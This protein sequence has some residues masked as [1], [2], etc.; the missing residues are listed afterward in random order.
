MELHNVAAATCR[1]PALGAG[2]AVRLCLPQSKQKTSV[3]PTAAKRSGGIHPSSKNNLRK[4]KLATW[5]DPSTPFHDRRDDMSGG[6]TIQPHGLYP[7]RC[8]AMNHRRYIG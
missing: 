8:M 1:H 7:K 5:E 3:I 6:G 4:V 2:V